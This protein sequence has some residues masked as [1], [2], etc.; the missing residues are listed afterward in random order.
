MIMLLWLLI[1]AV[2]PPHSTVAVDNERVVVRDVG[3]PTPLSI[4]IGSA[5]D[6]V[7]VFL[8]DGKVATSHLPAKARPSL[9][10]VPSWWN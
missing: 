2:E 10:A 8:D 5:H 9:R 6:A 3:A 7:V 1:A 4:P